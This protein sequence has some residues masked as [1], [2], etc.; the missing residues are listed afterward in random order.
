MLKLHDGEPHV[1]LGFHRD[2]YEICALLGYYTVLSGSCVPFVSGQLIG[3][4]FKE[5]EVQE[6]EGY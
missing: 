6:G 2:V 5:Q 1:I 3:P 4:I